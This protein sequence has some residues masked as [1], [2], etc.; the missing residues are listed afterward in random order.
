MHLRDCALAH[1]ILERHNFDIDLPPMQQAELTALTVACEQADLDMV[2]QLL[3]DGADVNATVRFS[4]LDLGVWR[5]SFV[6]ALWFAVNIPPQHP[7]Q[8]IAGV[9]DDSAPSVIV[10]EAHR[11]AVVRLLRMHGASPI[12][13]G[14]APDAAALIASSPVYIRALVEGA[15]DKL[16]GDSEDEGSSDEDGDA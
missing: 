16:V 12:M 3:E 11:V 2:Q 1:S 5:S 15:N 7:P 10:D 8:V 9:K 13:D 6:T 14:A 4:R